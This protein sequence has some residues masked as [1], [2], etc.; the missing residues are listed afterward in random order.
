MENSMKAV[1][2]DLDGTLIDSAPD[3]CAAVNKM[4]ACEGIAPI[5]LSTVTSF[6]GNGM[7]K[8]VERVI[9]YVDL[10]LERHQDLTV[11]T[12]GFYNQSP[13]DLTQIYAGVMACLD[14][15]RSKGYS[16][17]ICTN[18]PFSLTQSVTQE[19]E[20]SRYFDVLVGAD[21]LSVKKPDPAPLHYC[22][23]EL[24]FEEALYV[25]DSEIDYQTAQNALVPFALFSGGYRKESLSFFKN[26]TIFDTFKE[27]PEIIRKNFS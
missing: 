25:G 1:V 24:G 26:A 9:H 7:P 3:I 2:F 16:L 5:E 14:L 17:G 8:L 23:K 12:L 22:I 21:T 4:L 27:L 6:I 20:I 15:L 13:S 19:L 18:K 10:P 11:A